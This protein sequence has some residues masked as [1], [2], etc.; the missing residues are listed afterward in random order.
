[1]PTSEDQLMPDSPEHWESWLL[2]QFSECHDDARV[3]LAAHDWAALDDVALRLNG[4]AG[5]LDMVISQGFSSQQVDARLSGLIDFLRKTMLQA[6][7]RDQILCQKEVQ[8]L[9]ERQHIVVSAQHRR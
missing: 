4:L 1:M 5:Q 2:Q 6:Q 3:A 8:L 9:A 7:Y